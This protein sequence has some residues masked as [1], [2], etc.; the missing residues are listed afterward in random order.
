MKNITLENA[1]PDFLEKNSLQFKAIFFSGFMV[2]F[3]ICLSAKFL[4]K[5]WSSWLPIEEGKHS[6]A[7]DAST[8]VY[9]F[10]SYLT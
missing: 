5:Q 2:F 8:A 1:D 6:V 4:P 7:Q 10:M 9:S 3:I